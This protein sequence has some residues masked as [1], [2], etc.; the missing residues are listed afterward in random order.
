MFPLPWLKGS[1]MFWR[2]WA[3]PFFLHGYSASMC[4]KKKGFVRPQD[5]CPDV[6]ILLYLIS[7]KGQ[8]SRWLAC[9][10]CQMPYMYINITTSGELSC[11][12]T[13]PSLGCFFFYTWK[14]NSHGSRKEKPKSPRT[15]W[16]PLTTVMETSSHGNASLATARKASSGS[17]D[18]WER[19]I[20]SRPLTNTQMNLQKNSYSVTTGSS[21]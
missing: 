4:K 16:H 20:T 18:S 6:L 14:L 11:S 17:R 1:A 13:K 8:A 19:R 2:F 10:L 9:G 21:S 5:S 12:L 15:R 3:S 7:G